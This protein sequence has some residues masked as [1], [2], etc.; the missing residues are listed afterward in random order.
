MHGPKLNHYFLQKDLHWW[1]GSTLISVLD[2]LDCV[3]PYLYIIRRQY[4]HHHHYFQI[5][6]KIG[7]S[8]SPIIQW[9]CIQEPDFLE[10][11]KFLFH[12]TKVSTVCSCNTSDYKSWY[13]HLLFC[14]QKHFSYKSRIFVMEMWTVCN[15]IILTIKTQS[16]KVGY[17]WLSFDPNY[18]VLAAA[19]SSH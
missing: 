8:L 12:S 1:I 16:S 4:R 14:N 3:S 9:I 18:C 6:S 15:C 19:S 7:Y 11:P 13:T 17:C 10:H 5:F 2:E